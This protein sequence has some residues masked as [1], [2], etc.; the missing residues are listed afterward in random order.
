MPVQ[1][2]AAATSSALRA[3]LSVVMPSVLKRVNCSGCE[4]STITRPAT[5]S[6]WSFV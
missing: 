1:E 4:A 2:S 6:G 5:W 3:A